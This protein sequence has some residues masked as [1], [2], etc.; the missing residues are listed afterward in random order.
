MREVRNIYVTNCIFSSS[1]KRHSGAQG[2]S[3]TQAT[4]A[5]APCIVTGAEDQKVPPT[6]GLDVSPS[7]AVVRAAGAEAL[8]IPGSPRAWNGIETCRSGS[9]NGSV[10]VSSCWSPVTPWSPETPHV[11]RCRFGSLTDKSPWS[12]ATPQTTQDRPISFQGP[13]PSPPPA[14]GS[15]KHIVQSPI[16]YGKVALSPGGEIRRNAAS[17]GI[18]LNLR[19]LPG[20]SA[21]PVPVRSGGMVVA[22]SPTSTGPIATTTCFPVA[23]CPGTTTNMQ[24]TSGQAMPPPTIN[25][26]G[27]SPPALI[28]SVVTPFSAGL[29][30]GVPLPAGLR[31]GA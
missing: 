16:S 11:G 13:P 14:P 17:L 5:L 18:P 23:T 3:Y 15:S 8:E 4:M 22:P 29:R 31:G 1:N 2:R 19:T 25:V 20:E 27:P 12:P 21:V 10:D 9:R 6:M 26:L 24:M 7:L 30:S 28:R